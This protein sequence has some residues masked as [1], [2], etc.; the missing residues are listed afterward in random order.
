MG[1]NNGVLVQWFVI[2]GSNA[3]RTLPIAYNIGYVMVATYV[4]SSANYVFTTF[5]NTEKTL[6]AYRIVQRTASG[7]STGSATCN[8]ICIGS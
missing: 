8:C 3:V 2:T 6:S 7:N 1:V 4:S 5:V